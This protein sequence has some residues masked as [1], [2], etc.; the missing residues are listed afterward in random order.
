MDVKRMI[1]AVVLSLAV[2]FVWIRFF[3]PAVPEKENQVSQPQK[4]TVVEKKQTA[5]IPA[6]IKVVGQ[7]ADRETEVEVATSKYKVALSSKGGSIKNFNYKERDVELV[8]NKN[9]SGAKGVFDFSV[10]LSREEFEH[11]NALENTIWNY[12]RISDNAIKFSTNISVDGKPALLEKTYTFLDNNYYF[13]IE[14]NIRNLGNRTISFPNGNIIISPGDFLGPD[15]DFDNTY[16]KLNQVY[17]LNNELMKCE[18]GGGFFSKAE[19]Y[20]IENG[21][22]KWAGIM[23]RY[24]LLIMLPENFN[25]TGVICDTRIDKGHKAGMYISADKIEP[26][27]KLAKSFKVYAGEKNK[28][29]LAA[30]DVNLK[31]A[32]DVSK[33]IEPIR[34]FLL[35]CLLNI[36][37]VIGNIGWSLVIFSILSKIVLMPLTIK[38][39][40]S[41]QRMQALTP[42]MNELKEK[43]KGKPDVLNKE[44]MKLYKANKVNPLGGCLPMLL[45]MPFFFAL[46]SALIN[47]IDLWQAPFIFW[48]KDLSLPD[49]VAV[50]PFININLNILP[51]IM[52]ATSFYQQKLMPSAAGGQQQKMMMLMPLVFIVIFWNMPSGLVLYWTLQNIMQILHQLYTNSKVKP[53]AA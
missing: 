6:E 48:M 49:T 28:D 11:G 23:S 19:D 17:Y 14:Y 36:N 5:G 20:K 34:D 7:R 35:W 41:M 29:I 1:I 44:M 33:W 47:S 27:Q 51:L 2:W 37:K 32:A 26:G 21:E 50:I 22:I 24:F 30:V 52:T 18:K 42:K 16:N 40:N 10:Y 38:S 31:D 53:A 46:W 39:T 12:T 43:Y 15:M 8:V 25:G 9:K 45:Q 13:N 4:E 3:N